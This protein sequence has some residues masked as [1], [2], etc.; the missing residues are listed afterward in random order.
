MFGRM[1]VRS[2]VREGRAFGFVCAFVYAVQTLRRI[3][4]TFFCLILRSLGGQA[5]CTMSLV[6][7]GSETLHSGAT[8]ALVHLD[9]VRVHL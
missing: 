5:P 8:R 6:H 2:W 3:L 7:H 4:Q 9:S 1:N